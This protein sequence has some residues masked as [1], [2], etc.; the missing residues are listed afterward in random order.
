MVVRESQ[1]ELREIG[2]QLGYR[3]VDHASIKDNG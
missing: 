1:A 3:Y 2:I